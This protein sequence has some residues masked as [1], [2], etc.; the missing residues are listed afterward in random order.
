MLQG[1]LLIRLLTRVSR[2]VH[3][4]SE[5]RF[6]FEEQPSYHFQDVSRQDDDATDGKNQANYEMEHKENG[7]FEQKPIKIFDQFSNSKD[8]E[9]KERAEKRRPRNEKKLRR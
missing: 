7:E 4:V 9:I 3:I 2:G 1:Y 5:A 8:R 6:R